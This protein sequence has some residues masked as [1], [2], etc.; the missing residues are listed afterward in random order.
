MSLHRTENQ[1]DSLSLVINPANK[2]NTSTNDDFV[3]IDIRQLFTVLLS[4]WRELLLASIIFAI[5][6]AAFV[7]YTNITKPPVY[8]TSADV[9]I[10]RVTNDISLVDSF[11]TTSEEATLS[12]SNNARRQALV[13]LVNS[14]AVAEKVAIELADILTKAERQPVVL[15]GM[16]SAQV[17]LAADGR[18]SSLIRINVQA[19][20]PEKAQAIANSWARHYVNHINSVYNQVP[21]E[22]YTSVEQQKEQAYAEYQ[23]AQDAFVAFAQDNQLEALQNQIEQKS[24]LRA[25]Y[26]NAQT[27]LTTAIVEQDRSARMKLFNDLVSTQNDVL[28]TVFAQNS[29]GKI[30]HL[31][32][33]Y[34]LTTLTQ[35]QLQQAQNLRQQIATSTE[36]S[37][38]DALA[39]Q[40]LKTQIYATV[41]GSS[42]PSALNITLETPN[43]PGG[44]NL[45][46]EVDALIATLEA[47]NTQVQTEIATSSVQLLT[48]TGYSYLEQYAADRLAISTNAITQSA[49]VENANA[50]ELSAAIYQRYY[51]LFS[52]GELAQL[53]QPG[54]NTEAA[55]D[56]SV[57]IEKLN[58]EIELLQGQ[59]TVEQAKQL[60][61]TQQR[62][63]QWK[64]FDTLS[65]KVVELQLARTAA[66]TE[67]RFASEAVAPLSPQPGQNTLFI[68]VGAGVAGFALAMMAIYI[69]NLLGMRPLLA[70]LQQS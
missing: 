42:L 21:V 47:Y 63:L 27:A 11:R 69:A 12:E 13:F 53:S 55:T 46:D 64:T 66:N 39:L 62:D 10:A 28:Y 49:T 70:N 22:T 26:L 61:L 54:S 57:M 6:G 1:D 30:N 52:I 3:D 35:R 7:L 25:N 23:K 2:N 19:D 58:H 68:A 48:G 50:S 36:P 51:D 9:I 38:S 67:V 34:R 43:V 37:S 18:V 20:S 31:A 59:L 15:L 14:G 17:P 24:Q 8:E 44:K 33:L 5:A 40:L 4:W 41:E 45:L 56:L 29:Q 16:V 60:F 65:N 32:E